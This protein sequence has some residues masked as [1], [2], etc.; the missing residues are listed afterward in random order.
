MEV[1]SVVA[2]PVEEDAVEAVLL[3]ADELPEE[4]SDPEDD[5]TLP[6]EEES[7]ELVVDESPPLFP[8]TPAI[9]PEELAVGNV[10]L[11]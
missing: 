7:L 6:E 2:V 3:E 9:A 1:V 11:F 10:E 4:S 8:P 5:A